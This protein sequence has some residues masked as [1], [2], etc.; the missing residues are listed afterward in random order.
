MES[1]GDDDGQPYVF[2]CSLT[3]DDLG[4]PGLQKTVKMGRSTFLAYQ[5]LNPE[6]SASVNYDTVWPAA[7]QAGADAG[8]DSVWDSAVWDSAL[9]D[10][11][12]A[13]ASRT[14]W[15]SIGVTGFAVSPQVQST[16]ANDLEVQAEFVSFDVSYVIGGLH[17]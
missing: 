9:W 4:A 13:K 11:G 10:G 16:I 14:K 6:V 15:E 17:V 1:G 8:E 3:P 2:Q 7:P 12:L 5:S